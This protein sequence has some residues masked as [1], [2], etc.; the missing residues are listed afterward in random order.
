MSKRQSDEER[1]VRFFEDAHY[2]RASAVF[3]MIKATMKRRTLTVAAAADP[4]PKQVRK[5]RS[6]STTPATSFPPVEVA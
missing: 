5:R 3:N 1:I 4:K 2:E 6:K